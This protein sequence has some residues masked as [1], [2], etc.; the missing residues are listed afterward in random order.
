MRSRIPVAVAALA[1]ILVALPGVAA[2]APVI[3]Y[4][5]KTVE[6]HDPACRLSRSDLFRCP[7]ILFEYPV[8]ERTPRPA[9]AAA[10]NQAVRDFLVTSVGEPRK[11]ASI[12][13]AMH[14]FMKEYEEYKKQGNAATGYWEERTVAILYQSPAMVSVQFDTSFYFGGAHPQYAATFASFNATTGATIKLDDVL[15]AGYRPRLTRI[16]E[17]VFRTQAGI[18]P[19]T[20]LYDAGYIFFKN[21]RF[22]LNDNFWFGPK[23]VTFF[24]NT[25]EIAAYAMGTTQLLLTYR[26]IKD[27]IRPDGLLRSMR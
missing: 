20:T 15:V 27:L 24:Y 25:Y 23:G 5:V 12:E 11:Y 9:V 22:A 18:K 13:A 4:T 1:A 2:P 21:G 14:A 19:G 8:V 3:V 6:R 7:H 26:Q 17:S 10:I 16:G